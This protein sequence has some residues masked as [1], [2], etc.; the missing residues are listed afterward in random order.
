VPAFYT[1]PQTIDDIVN[2]TVGRLLDLFS[3][4][5]SGLVQRWEG[6]QKQAPIAGQQS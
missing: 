2:H 5:H 6:M 1:Q 3:I 4:A